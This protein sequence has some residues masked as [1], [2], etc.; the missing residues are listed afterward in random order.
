VYWKA[1]KKWF[2]G[3]IDKFE[4]D[5]DDE[6]EPPYHVTYEDG[7]D[8]WVHYP[9]SHVMLDAPP[10]PRGKPPK[11]TGNTPTKVR[12][13]QRQP[14]SN[15]V[16]IGLPG[17]SQPSSNR[18]DNPQLQPMRPPTPPLVAAPG[19][20]AADNN[21]QIAHALTLNG[22]T[23]GVKHSDPGLDK[24]W[25]DWIFLGVFAAALAYIGHLG[26]VQNREAV[27]SFTGHALAS[28]Q[29]YMPK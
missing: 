29:S 17:R 5:E 18:V 16:E 13:P 11:R 4:P 26:Y 22:A 14:K 9:Q 12:N 8:E 20:S 15:R 10:R 21:D 25:L 7:D 1:D 19:P 6:S 2:G 3:V 23:P 28:V 24:I 27:D